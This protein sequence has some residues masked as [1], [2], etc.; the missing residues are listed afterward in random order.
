MILKIK[1]ILTNPKVCKI[2]IT[3]TQLTRG[4]KKNCET[5][6][7]LVHADKF[8]SFFFFLFS[9]FLSFF[10]PESER[11]AFSRSTNNHQLTAHQLT[12]N[13]HKQPS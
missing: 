12:I 3:L 6:P 13:K 2:N 10:L 9:F 8:F 11:G 7:T 5:S 1:N 4:I